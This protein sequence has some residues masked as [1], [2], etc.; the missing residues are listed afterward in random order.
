MGSKHTMSSSGSVGWSLVIY[1]INIL[2]YILVAI[3]ATILLVRVQASVLADDVATIVPFDKTFG[4]DTSDTDGVLTV[5]KAIK[6]IDRACFKR[7][8]IY[9]AKSLPVLLAVT[10]TFV[11]AFM[12][13]FL[14]WA[15]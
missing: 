14:S 8:C 15:Q 1:G 5:Q 6:S 11:A 13:M 9:L 10:F 12:I 2:L 3:P 7:V 4:Q